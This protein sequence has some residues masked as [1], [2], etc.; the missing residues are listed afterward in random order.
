MEIDATLIIFRGFLRVTEMETVKFLA[1]IAGQALRLDDVEPQSAGQFM[2]ILITAAGLDDDAALL[3]FE[4]ILTD[5]VE[6]QLIESCEFHEALDNIISPI[7]MVELIIGAFPKGEE[8][9][10]ASC[11]CKLCSGSVLKPDSDA[12]RMIRSNMSPVDFRNLVAQIAELSCDKPHQVKRLLDDVYTGRDEFEINDTLRMMLESSW[13][14]DILPQK[15][16]AARSAI[17]E[18]FLKPF[19]FTLKVISDF[20]GEM[21]RLS[22]P[23]D[24]NDQVSDRSVSSS[25]DSDIESR[26]SLD[27]FVVDSDEDDEEGESDD[28]SEVSASSAESLASSESERPVKKKKQR[29]FYSSSE[30]DDESEASSESGSDIPIKKK[31]RKYATSESDGSPKNKRRN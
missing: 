22:P 10:L 3:L 23:P 18:Y 2:R 4:H 6:T 15:R 20:C 28:N 31:A 29:Q 12:W 7:H 16:K 30:S 8:I 27:D 17:G 13:I 21:L 24:R 11:I 1:P 19:P 25:S 14:M 9:K 26:G 5:L